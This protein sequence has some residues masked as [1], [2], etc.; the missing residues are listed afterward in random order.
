MS[1]LKNN[2]PDKKEEPKPGKK[3]AEQFGATDLIYIV[4]FVIIC[5]IGIAIALD[6]MNGKFVNYINWKVEALSI[7]S[8]VELISILSAF[9]IPSVNE[10]MMQ[11]YH[12]SRDDYDVLSETSKSTYTNLLIVSIVL[13]AL[14]AGFYVFDFRLTLLGVLACGLILICVFVVPVIIR[15]LNID[16]TIVNMATKNFSE[17]YCSP[18][19]KLYIN[20][21]YFNIA[22]LR[23]DR[24]RKQIAVD[25]SIESILCAKEYKEISSAL[26]ETANKA[27]RTKIDDDQNIT[28]KNVYTYLAERL[29]QISARISDI[30]IENALT[31]T[32]MHQLIGNIKAAKRRAR[33]FLN[34]TNDRVQ[35]C[36]L[37]ALAINSLCSSSSLPSKTKA[38]AENLLNEYLEECT[39]YVNGE[40][41]KG[42]EPYLGCYADSIIIVVKLF[43]L[44]V[45]N[46]DYWL[47]RYFKDQ[48]NKYQLFVNNTKEIL[49]YVILLFLF[50]DRTGKDLL[51]KTDEDVRAL[52]DQLKQN[53]SHIFEK[54]VNQLDC[55]D[56]IRLYNIIDFTRYSTLRISNPE[57]MFMISLRSR[58]RHELCSNWTY[59]LIYAVHNSKAFYDDLLKSVD[60]VFE[61]NLYALIRTYKDNNLDDDNFVNMTSETLTTN[62]I[63][64]L[65]IQDIMDTVQYMLDT[66]KRQ[67]EYLKRLEDIKFKE[68]ILKI[69]KSISH[70]EDY[71]SKKKLHDGETANIACFQIE[72][73]VPMDENAVNFDMFPNY[74]TVDELINK[75]MS[76]WVRRSNKDNSQIREID[77]YD[78]DTIS[79]IGN[80]KPDYCYAPN[81]ED[82]DKKLKKEIKKQIPNI[83][84][85]KPYLSNSSRYH[86]FDIYCKNDA[87]Q[88]YINILPDPVSIDAVSKEKARHFL[89]SMR[90]EG[91]DIRQE[92]ETR[93]KELVDSCV[94]VKLN[95]E[96]SFVFDVENKMLVYRLK[97]NDE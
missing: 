81:L 14:D 70:K 83:S 82:V 26:I 86:L 3:S 21:K 37:I 94:I 4:D 65:S 56:Y 92:R 90:R 18:K 38:E 22:E 85:T 77:E 93:I 30:N 36:G 2:E 5:V 84:K 32:E 27:K 74:P 87:I 75:C 33:V 63:F 23:N 7:D 19:Q 72:I 51:G 58:M 17:I 54:A 49:L 25:N 88:F 12:L 39:R 20:S 73:I 80:F 29:C 53:S 13:I 62:H 48:D 24:E 9:I 52:H 97:D 76:Q 34:D 59:L 47:L 6:C 44:A 96:Y 95:V 71:I 55:S 1:E 79:Y 45:K 61:D 31:E 46:N 67:K 11:K 15:R 40:L 8:V 28:K 89:F 69:N 60:D 64:S 57:G 50:I 10:N 91:K 43:D 78:L 41:P 42:Y 66:P 68:A 35:Y 16:K